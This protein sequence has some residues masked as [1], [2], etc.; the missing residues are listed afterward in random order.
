MIVRKFLQAKSFKV[1]VLQTKENQPGQ[2]DFT[3][4]GSAVEKALKFVRDLTLIKEQIL[5]AAWAA[6]GPDTPPPRLTG[7]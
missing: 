2:M 4:R 7:Y 3:Y 5:P 6:E 1:K